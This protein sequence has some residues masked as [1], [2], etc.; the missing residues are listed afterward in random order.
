[1]IERKTRLAIIVGSLGVGGSSRLAIETY[2]Y[3]RSL[4]YQVYLIVLSQIDEIWIPSIANFEVVQLHNLRSNMRGF[5]RV[6][7]LIKLRQTIKKLKID[8]IISLIFDANVNTLMATLGMRMPCLV[9]EGTDI[10]AFDPPNRFKIARSLLY[11]RAY[12]VILCV[13]EILEKVRQ[14]HPSWK[15]I[16]LPNP[17]VRPLIN[18][19]ADL[20]QKENLIVGAGRLSYEKGFDL[21]ISSFSLIANEFPNWRI[22]IYGNGPEQ[23]SL[24]EIIYRNKLNDQIVLKPPIRYLGNVLAKAAI[25]ALPSRREGVPNVLSEAMYSKAACLAFDLPGGIRRLLKPVNPEYL[26][27]P[28]EIDDFAFKL[29][30]L[31]MIPE[32]RSALIAGYEN[33]LR[34]Y[35]P[36]KTLG[37][38]HKV[39]Q[40]TISHTFKNNE[41]RW[42]KALEAW[43][44]E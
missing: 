36:Q 3:F 12:R 26:I 7:R 33:I 20:N 42:P 37:T 13:P 11:P 21:L 29:K 40:D 28:Y 30:Q 9:S 2:N 32:K 38:W 6:N 17:V 1:M 16:T 5:K 22:E 43:P 27:K 31:M 44:A 10:T 23:N 39:V 15:V 4:N 18:G 19:E 41:I 24:Q 14:D 25:F 8:V 34:D 35:E